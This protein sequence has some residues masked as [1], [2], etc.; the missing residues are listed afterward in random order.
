M[1]FDYNDISLEERAFEF[2]K[3]LQLISH[4]I[5]PLKE[6]LQSNKINRMSH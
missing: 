4:L 2:I 3:Q 1:H 6:K 5:H